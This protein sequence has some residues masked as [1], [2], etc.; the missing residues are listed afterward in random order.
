LNEKKL[1]RRGGVY[2][3]RRG[4]LNGSALRSLAQSTRQRLAVPVGARREFAM[5][6]TIAPFSLRRSIAAAR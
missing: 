3:L 4:A 2:S 1:Q 5:R 6:C